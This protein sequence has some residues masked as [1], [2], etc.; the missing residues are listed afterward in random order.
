LSHIR[1]G[2]A[3]NDYLVAQ[4]RAVLDELRRD[5]IEAPT[6]LVK[7]V[8]A[9]LRSCGSGQRNLHEAR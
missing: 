9:E 1:V 7:A 6:E 2:W 5:G 8:E 4:R 3:A